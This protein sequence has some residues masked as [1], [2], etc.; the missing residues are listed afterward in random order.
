MS[1]D[2]SNEYGLVSHYHFGSTCPEVVARQ[3]G[4]RMSV[5]PLAVSGNNDG[6]LNM[7]VKELHRHQNL[8]G[9][10]IV[11]LET[12]KLRV[13]LISTYCKQTALDEMLYQMACHKLAER[14]A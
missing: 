2:S 6:G 12:G 5:A 9:E 1:Y 7:K 11:E 8:N 3:A 13:R 10:T 4:R 14:L